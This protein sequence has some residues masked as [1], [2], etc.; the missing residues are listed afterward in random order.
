MK[1]KGQLV[2]HVAW[3]IVVATTTIL[4]Y[5][6]GAQENIQK[7]ISSINVSVASLGATVTDQ[8]SDISDL[9]TEVNS[10][11]QNIINLT[12][13]LGIETLKADNTK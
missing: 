4:T 7:D 10:A 1:N 2:P 3:G 8:S 13:H 9:K 5:Y 11:N 6:Y 12:T